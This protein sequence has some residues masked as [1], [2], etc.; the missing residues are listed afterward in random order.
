[1]FVAQVIGES[2]NRRI[3][4]GAYCLFR[5]PVTGSRNGRVVL[6]EHRDI[7]DPDLEGPFT[8][9]VYES[10]KEETG[11]GSWRHT[12]IRLKPD[13]TASGYEPIVLRDVPEDEIRVVAELLEVLPSVEEA[14]EGG[15]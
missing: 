12:E 4:N 8:L 14:V 13:T 6:V 1:L 15:A 9:K 3:P 5:Y 10:D 11:D 7:A 2:M